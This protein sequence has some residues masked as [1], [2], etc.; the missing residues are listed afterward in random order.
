MVLGVGGKSKLVMQNVGM[1]VA[2]NT[3]ERVEKIGGECTHRCS[4]LLRRS[5]GWES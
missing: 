5:S 4:K 2:V 3:E 1:T